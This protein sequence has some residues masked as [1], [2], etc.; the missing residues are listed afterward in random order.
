MSRLL[1]D[2]R[3]ESNTLAK[4]FDRSPT[5]SNTLTKDCEPNLELGR[6]VA[7]RKTDQ[8]GKNFDGQLMAGD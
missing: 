6:G 4:D 1:H 7:F 8:T 5:R 2:K 3:L